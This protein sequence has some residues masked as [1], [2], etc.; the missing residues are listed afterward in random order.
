MDCNENQDSFLAHHEWSRTL[1]VVRLSKV[2]NTS[3]ESTNHRSFEILTL[4]SVISQYL[5]R[6]KEPKFVSSAIR[7]GVLQLFVV[8]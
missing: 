7:H 3:Q 6:K 8:I 5:L 4:V 2:N 1:R